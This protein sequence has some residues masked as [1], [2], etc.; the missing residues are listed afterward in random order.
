MTLITGERTA[1]DY[2]VNSTRELVRTTSL[3]RP[4]HTLAVAGLDPAIHV[5]AESSIG[6]GPLGQAR[7]ER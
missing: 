5:S 7:G 6:R 2:S 4:D 1:T 3:V